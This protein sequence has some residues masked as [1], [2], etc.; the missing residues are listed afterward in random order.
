NY[1]YIPE[2]SNVPVNPKLHE[3]FKVPIT[4]ENNLRAIA[5]AERWFGGGRDLSD[6]V[7]LGPRAGF[8]I[9]VVQNGELAR[10]VRQAAGEIGYWRWSLRSSEGKELQNAVSASAVWQRLSGEAAGSK[11]PRDLRRAL[12]DIANTSGSAWTEVVQDFA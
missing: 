7:I 6:Y 2:W 8:G 10:G 1:R 12:A 4:L 5:L 9:A 3:R 11:V